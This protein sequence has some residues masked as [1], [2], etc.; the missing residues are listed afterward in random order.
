MNQQKAK[1]LRRKARELGKGLPYETYEQTNQRIRYFKQGDKAIP[2]DTYTLK[3]S[4]S[5]IK[6]IYK[7]LKNA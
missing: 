3:L 1:E 7:R 2:Y 5:C 6:G 4:T